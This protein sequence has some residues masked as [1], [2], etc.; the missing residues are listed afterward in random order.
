MANRA[1]A[2]QFYAKDWFDLNVRRMDAD[3]RGYYMDILAYMWKDSD[4]QCSI[5]SEL[6][7]VAKVLGISKQK[8]VKVFQQIQWE[9]DP[10]FTEKDGRFIS[11]RLREERHKQDKYR[12]EQSK[13]GK[14]SA[15]QRRNR[16]TNR[17]STAVQPD[18]QPEVNSS[19]SSSTSKEERERSFKSNPLLEELTDKL[20][21]KWISLHSK[22][23]LDQLTKQVR[24]LIFD[25]VQS[26]QKPDAIS[27]AL[28][29][30]AEGKHAL[31]F[32]KFIADFTEG[33]TKEHGSKAEEKAKLEKALAAAKTGLQVAIDN[34]YS[35]A[36][37]DE[38]RSR[39]DELGKK[40]KNY[41]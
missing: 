38:R 15:E 37:I 20:L 29:K 12:R 39:V 36:D 5:T 14:K 34:D 26:G 8:C 30:L 33:N 11:K 7:T 13:K 23:P 10:I 17:G 18:T 28:K 9:N 22:R 27:Y 16:G 3:A 41:G 2:F 6:S 21:N 32:G 4:D 40:L 1:P 24:K 19:S 31:D 35:Q 25:S